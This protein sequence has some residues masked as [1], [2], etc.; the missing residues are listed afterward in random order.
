MNYI[1]QKDSM[2]CGV[3]CVAN[4]VGINYDEALAL[5][6]YPDYAKTTGYKCKYIVQA[7][8]NAGINARLKHIRREQPLSDLPVGTII[9]L[10][11]SAR[12]PHQHYLLKVE[13]GWLDP[14]VNM[15]QDI[16]M[17][18]AKAGVRSELPGRAYYAIGEFPE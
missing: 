11:R 14:W 17:K 8:Q 10:E 7:L 6:K 4:R 2:G 3:A 16:S 12:Y 15:H 1:P 13:D 5:F 18:Q 9:F